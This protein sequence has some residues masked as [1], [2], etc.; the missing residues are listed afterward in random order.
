MTKRS[1]CDFQFFAIL[2]AQKKEAGILKLE[3]RN[4]GLL[5]SLYLVYRH[6]HEPYSRPRRTNGRSICLIEAF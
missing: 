5:I 6:C 3:A 2:D 4:E 1:W